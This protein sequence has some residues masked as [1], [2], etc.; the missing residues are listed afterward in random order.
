MSDV[1][2]KYRYPWFSATLFL[3]VRVFLLWI[4]IPIGVLLWLLGWPY[5]RFKKV[6]ISQL[7]GWLDL[8]LAALIHRTLLAKLVENPLRFRKWNEIATT[9]DQVHFTDLL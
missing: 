7:I 9:R 3:I 8:N 4:V 2:P 1:P 5:W 6:P